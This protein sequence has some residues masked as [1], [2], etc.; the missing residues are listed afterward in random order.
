M[1][2]KSG[3]TI[4]ECIISLLVL[5]MIFGLVQITIPLVNSL[6]SCSGKDTTDWYLFLGKL[7]DSEYSFQ[8]LAATKHTLLLS[9]PVHGENYQLQ[10]GK[11]AV[12]LKTERGGYLPVL[13][14]Y[15]PNSLEIKR[16][17]RNSVTIACRLESGKMK[18]AKICFKEVR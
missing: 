4:L 11:R 5:I 2:R 1:L 6:H 9:S 12:Y 7:E 8:L 10:G 13:V 3:F 14:N 16:N 18:N 15:Q 17:S